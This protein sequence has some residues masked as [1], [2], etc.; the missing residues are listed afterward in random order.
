MLVSELPQSEPA[1]EAEVIVANRPVVGLPPHLA[2][3]G[4]RST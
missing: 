3:S 2:G 4:T 1:S